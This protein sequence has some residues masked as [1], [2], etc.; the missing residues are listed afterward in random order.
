MEAQQVMKRDCS[1]LLCS[2]LR[3]WCWA[4]EANFILSDSTQGSGCDEVSGALRAAGHQV[5]S[6]IFA[7]GK[8][9]GSNIDPDKQTPSIPPAENITC[10]IAWS[11]NSSVLVLM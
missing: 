11:S 7:E 10:G 9:K 5:N 4:G 8:G 6:R 1:L 3:K 2:K